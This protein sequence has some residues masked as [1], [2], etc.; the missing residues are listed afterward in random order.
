LHEHAPPV[1]AAALG[2]AALVLPASV[3]G[4]GAGLE[5]LQPFALA[6][7][8]GLATSLIVVLLIVPGLYPALAGLE[9]R[10]V[11]PDEVDVEQDESGEQR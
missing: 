11:P 3:M 7:L 10:P 4:R 1:L 5:L 6:L 9:P 8:G 2:V